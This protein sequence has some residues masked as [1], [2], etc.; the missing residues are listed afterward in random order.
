MTQKRSGMTRFNRDHVQALRDEMA[1]GPNPAYAQMVA[2]GQMTDSDMI[3]FAICLANSY[4]SGILLESFKETAA[5]NMD[6]QRRRSV[7]VTAALF[8][9]TAAFDKDGGMRIKSIGN[10]PDMITFAVQQLVNVGMTVAEAMRQLEPPP[11]APC[12]M[13]SDIN[14]KLPELVH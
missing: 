7:L 4:F 8:G 6:L 9:A 10:D 14:T 11:P 5:V 12:K 2:K 13:K 3:D 1:K